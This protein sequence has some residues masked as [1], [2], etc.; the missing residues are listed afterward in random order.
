MSHWRGLRFVLSLES[1]GCAGNGE[2]S[3][4]RQWVRPRRGAEG[5][6]VVDAAKPNPKGCKES[7]RWSEQSED[8]RE[9]W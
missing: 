5:G 1:G 8:H 2:R 7:S 6:Y 9:R 4:H 3:E